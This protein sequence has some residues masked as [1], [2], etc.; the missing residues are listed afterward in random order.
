MTTTALYSTLYRVRGLTRTVAKAFAWLFGVQLAV[1]YVLATV[2]DAPLTSLAGPGLRFAAALAAVVI[3]APRV[4]NAVLAWI[5]A[6][7]RA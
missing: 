5:A 6:K 4:F 3:L 2:A 7:R 1:L